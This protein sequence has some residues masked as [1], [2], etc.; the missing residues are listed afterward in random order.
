MGGWRLLVVV[1]VLAAFMLGPTD[2]VAGAG[3][4][5]NA[6]G[7]GGPP[8]GYHTL[9]IEKAGVTFAVP[10]AWEKA[11][12]TRQ[13]T[14]AYIHR[15]KKSNP[16][17]AKFLTEHRDFLAKYGLFSASDL[18]ETY[19]D[20]INIVAVPSGNGSPIIPTGR[21]E[22]I[23]SAYEQN[24]GITNVEVNDATLGGAPAAAV[25][26]TRQE[27]VGKGRSLTLH[28]T[29]YVVATKDGFLEIDFLGRKD[30]RQDKT[31]QTMIQSV[32]F[33]E[34]TVPFAVNGSGTQEGTNYRGSVTG[35]LLGNGTFNGT[36]GIPPQPPPCPGPGVPFQGSANLAAAN[37]D[38]LNTNVSGTTCQ[39]GTT[40]SGD[41][42][43]FTFDAAGTYTI[44]AG[45]GCFT[46]ATGGGAVTAHVVFN[47]L[48]TASIN[49]S[50]NGTITLKNQPHCVR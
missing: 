49:I 36:Y 31:V 38:V 16:K 22:E 50:D 47:S 28:G 11:D 5:T 45:T 4:S 37:G 18:R 21:A 8:T 40:P 12:L 7:K 41:L 46:N 23:K 20:N 10:D 34:V 2:S 15:I 32:T 9:R 48:T 19:G 35:T 24:S 13:T 33:D 44:A 26:G 30:G 1:L 42:V 3:V 29:G 6:A 14:D 17:Q 27:P 39:S 25:T 43:L